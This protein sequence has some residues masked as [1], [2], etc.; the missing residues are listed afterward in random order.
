MTMRLHYFKELLLLLLLLLLL[1]PTKLTQIKHKMLHAGGGGGWLLPS[2]SHLCSLDAEVA[3]ET[4]QGFSCSSFCVGASIYFLGYL[5]C[6]GIHFS[7]F[8]I[9]G[10][11][12]TR[13]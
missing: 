12:L 10:V 3:F 6:E 2:P 8:M 5:Y 4:P 7:F 9:P 1:W 11:L 13:P